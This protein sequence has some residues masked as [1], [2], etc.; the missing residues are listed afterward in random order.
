MRSFR[1]AILCMALVTVHANGFIEREYTIQEVVA[2]SSNILIGKV[3]IVDD[4]KQRIVVAVERN[5]K[6]E[7]PFRD[8]RVNVAVGQI[9]PGQT[10]PEMLMKAVAQHRDAIV[11][12]T[13]ESQGQQSSLAG[14]VYVDDT[15]FQIFG[16]IRDD[17]QN[18]W[19]NFSHIEIFMHRTYTGETNRL[20]AI[21]EGILSEDGWPEVSDL[22]RVLVLT[23]NG[24]EIM[25]G[26]TEPT[27]AAITSQYRTTHESAA[28]GGVRN[29]DGRL[30]FVRTTNETHLPG[31]ERA[32]V[33]WLGYREVWRNGQQLDA[34]TERRIVEFVH[35]GGVAVVSGQDYDEGRSLSLRW[36]PPHAKGIELSHGTSKATGQ[37]DELLREPTTVDVTR[38]A[39]DDAWTGLANAYEAV[40]T[41]EDQRAVVV[42]RL[43][44]G[45]GT[46]LL[47]ALDCSSPD[48]VHANR[49]LIQ[50]LVYHAVRWSRK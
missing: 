4:E 12:Y 49:A 33:L 9:H 25:R 50:N 23:G 7:C 19:W 8:I 35:D 41:R 42:A 6:G 14:L 47:A 37:V 43:R 30:V 36:I 10:S 24:A 38:I 5:L 15:W 28:V 29:V 45:R 48:A 40:L 16:H 13:S 2:A 17:P 22:A 31:L 20:T 34:S 11:F 26:V 1:A 3:D 18:V 32:D 27:S 44:H 21:V 39:S 46:Y